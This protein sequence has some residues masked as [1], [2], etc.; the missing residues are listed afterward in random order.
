MVGTFQL[1]VEQAKRIAEVKTGKLNSMKIA[2][3]IGF[4]FLICATL[5]FSCKKEDELN[6][7]AVKVTLIDENESPIGDNSGVGVVLSRGQEKF[8]ATTDVNGQCVFPGFPFGIFNVKLEKEGFIS[9]YI[10]SELTHHENDSIAVH[11]FKMLEMPDIKISIDSI[12]IRPDEGYNF[13][14]WAYGKLYN[15]EGTPRIQYNGI[16][17]FGD[18]ENVSKDDYILYHYC[19]IV[20]HYIKGNNCQIWITN[21]RFSNLVPPGYDALYIRFYPV[22]PYPEWLTIREEALGEPSDVFEWI[23][24]NISD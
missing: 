7:V 8:Q 10:H 3:T 22:P 15:A 13:R 5:L 4:L 9:E 20:K 17:Y 14:L 16:A 2:K 11:S 24:P 18:H 23:V 6:D 19:A 21:W 1:N 12:T